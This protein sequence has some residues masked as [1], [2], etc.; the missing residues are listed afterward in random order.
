M[1][2]KNLSDFIDILDK[3]GELIRIK[4]H[5]NPHLE[6]AEITDR[7]VKS[8][9]NK[10]LLFEDTGTAFPLLINAYASEKRICLAL[11]TEG[12]DNIEKRINKIFKKFTQTQSGFIDK[13]KLIVHLKEINSW[14]PQR[15]ISRGLCQQNVMSEPDLSILPI[16][17]T[18]IHDG[19]P[20]ITLPVVH[21]IHPDTGIPNAGMYRMQVYDNKTTGMHWHP[22]KDAAKHYWAY[23]NKSK[24]MPITVTLGGDPVYAYV[25]S[26]PLPENIDEY[27]LAGFFRQK[28]VKLVKC[29]TNNIYVPADADF[30][31]EGYI[32]PTEDL[33]LEG[34][35][36]DHTGFYSLPDFYPVFHVTCITY[37]DNAV[38]PA[39][40]VGIPPQEDYWLGKATERIFLTPIRLTISPE[41]L[42]MHMPAEG[43]FHNIVLVKIKKT[44][45]GQ[46][47]KV[48]H[49]LWGAGQMMFNKFMLIFNEETDIYNYEEVFKHICKNV[50]ISDS[51]ILTKGPLDVLDH[52]T[53]KTGYGGKLGID[54]T[55]NIL[56]NVFDDYNTDNLITHTEHLKSQFPFIKDFNKNFL[57]IKYKTLLLSIEKSSTNDIILL[58]NE[59]LNNEN[60]SLIKF[61]IFIEALINPYDLKSVVWRSANNTEPSKDI[62]ILTNSKN[63]NMLFVDAT[64]KRKS[65]DKYKKEWPNI[66]T[67]DENTIALVDKKWNSYG[68]GEFISSPSL[69]YNTQKYGGNETIEQDIII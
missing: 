4:E 37:R 27:I 47:F 9:N 64:I 63:K 3:E 10:A 44:F 49:A 42:D 11:G 55:N 52:S 1:P 50:N 56:T 39:T 57:E 18:W 32:D 54:A 19:G 23:K 2:Y 38:Y 12:L 28:K 66:I 35:F 6:I 29:L 5:V 8:K 40:I 68:I 13:L 43:V 65:T 34:P 62:T 15:I 59:L 67:T 48:M 53:D 61:V 31:I 69:N 46:A 36:G 33:K 58:K 21:T 30:V 60:F 20:F 45:E 22:H 14:L 41:I 51:I 16:L 17:K 26:A 24:R 25:A 7:V